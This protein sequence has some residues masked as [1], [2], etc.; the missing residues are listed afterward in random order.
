VAVLAAGLKLSSA[1]ARAEDRLAGQMDQLLIEIDDAIARLGHPPALM[2]RQ[3]AMQDGFVRKARSGAE[4]LFKEALAGG[5]M[6]SATDAN[7][8]LTLVGKQVMIALRDA[9]LDMADD[10]IAATHAVARRNLALATT[11]LLLVLVAAAASLIVVR[12]RLV[13]PLGEITRVVTALASG[14]RHLEVPFNGRTDEIGAMAKAVLTFRDGLAQADSL[15]AAQREEQAAR[16]ARSAALETLVRGFEA[17]AGEMTALLA[18]G[19]AE[20]EATAQ[21]MTRIAGQT[22]ERAATV[23][24]AAEAASQGVQTVS[25][26][27]E[28]LASSIREISRQ[29]AMSSQITGKAVEDARRTDEIVQALAEGADKIGNVVGLITSIAGQTNLLALNATIEAARAGDA[30]K[31]FAVV[32]SEVKSLANQTMKATEEI[33][34]QIMQIQAATREAVAAIRGIGGV[35]RDV[36]AIATSIASAVEQQGAATAE[37]ARNVQQTAHATGAVTENIACVGQAANETGA[38]ANEVLSAAAT[39]SQQTR[40]LAGEVDAFVAGVRAA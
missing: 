33:D 1:D 29:V 13:R 22:D 26:A 16:E 28:E 2:A 37:I 4:N 32:A 7:L 23:T 8:R 34:G 30:G 21:S 5:S 24:K 6:D 17:K 9:A 14:N 10:T 20:L 36:S 25:V 15:R 12:R 39:V 11:V 3:A 31:G 19:S 18:A 35:I 40:S 27:A 38:A